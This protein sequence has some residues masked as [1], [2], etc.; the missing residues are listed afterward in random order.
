MD[1]IIDYDK[2]VAARERAHEKQ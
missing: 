1:Q 2:K